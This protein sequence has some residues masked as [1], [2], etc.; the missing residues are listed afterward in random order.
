[1]I[2]NIRKWGGN[3]TEEF[4]SLYNKLY[5]ENVAELEK[6]RMA[7]K[8]NIA[9]IIIPIII[10]IMTAMFSPLLIML[11]FPIMFI[12]IIVWTIKMIK[13]KNVEQT[14]NQY[15][16]ENYK[17]FFKEKIVTPLIEGIHEQTV[18]T[19]NKG[20]DKKIYNGACFENAYDRYKSED[21][22]NILL[23]DGGNSEPNYL[24][25][26]EVITEREY[27]DSNGNKHYATIYQGIMGYVDIGKQS[28][29][30]IK[31]K[32]NGKVT[33]WNKNKV[34][35]DMSEFEKYFD[36][37][38]DNKIEAMQILTSDIMADLLDFIVTSKVKFEIHII[39]SR[40]YIR[41]MTGAMFEPK[42]F[43]HSMEKELIWRYYNITKFCIDLTIKMC[44][45]VNETHI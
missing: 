24:T 2:F 30:F 6:Y 34:N 43:G 8:Q 27:T 15:N 14:K 7:V 5:N 13:K 9:K 31:I 36:V 26:S 12:G 38:A 21:Q 25:L 18:Y 40:L 23:S 28:Q 35:M 11:L 3:M 20:V 37:E 1:M 41:F 22:I 29:S 45:V 32:L 33:K 42:I 16:M 4:N 19:P 39:N 17:I 44:K 10:F